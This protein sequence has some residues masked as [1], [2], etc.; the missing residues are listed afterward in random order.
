MLGVTD[1]EKRSGI[2][3]VEGQ[4]ATRVSPSRPSRASTGARCNVV[5]HFVDGHFLL[6]SDFLLRLVCPPTAE[7]A[8]PNPPSALPPLPCPAPPHGVRPLKSVRPSSE[9]ED[10]NA[11]PKHQ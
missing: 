1:S 4:L 11:T 2:A 3:S 5:L 6:Q 9:E 7:P 8:R 10:S